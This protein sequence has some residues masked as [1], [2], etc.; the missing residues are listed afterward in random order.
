MSCID[1]YILHMH[2]LQTFPLL[3]GEIVDDFV[4]LLYFTPYNMLHDFSKEREK[5]E[6]I[7]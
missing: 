7:K 5:K 3:I 4:D 2:I 6:N 1:M